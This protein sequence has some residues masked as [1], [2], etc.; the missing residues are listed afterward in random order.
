MTWE[1]H[2]AWV[3]GWMMCCCEAIQGVD[4]ASVTHC[5]NCTGVV[6]NTPF[7]RKM[8]SR[9]VVALIK[10]EYITLPL[11]QNKAQTVE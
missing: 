8:P 10:L 2:G 6:A 5:I 11:T 3:L 4:D 7:L 9:A 1:W